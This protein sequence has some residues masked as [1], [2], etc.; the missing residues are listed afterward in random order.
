ML[1][2]LKRFIRKVKF[3]TLD[4]VKKCETYIN[5]GCALVDGP[6]C[7]FPR[8]SF[9]GGIKMDFGYDEILK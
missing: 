7:N 1:D 5:E 6:F 4:P 9:Q 3:N 8:C 2:K